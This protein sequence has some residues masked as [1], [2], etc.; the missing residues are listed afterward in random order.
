MRKLGGSP[1]D[2]ARLDSTASFVR[3]IL[4]IPAGLIIDRMKSIKNIYLISSL[5]ILPVQLVKG[6]AQNFQ[7]YFNIRMWEATN[8]R[9][10]MP[11]LNILNISSIK[12]D[13][14]INGMVTRRMA[15]SILG[16]ITPILAAYLITHFGGLENINSYRPLFYTQFVGNLFLFAVM[17]FKIQEPTIN[18]VDKKQNMMLSLKEMFHE[19]PGLKWVLFM[20]VIQFFFFGI[21]AS[22]MGLYFYEV[23]GADAYV[24]ALQST[25]GTLVTLALSVP[26]VRV[27]DKFGRIKMAYFA[28]IV[29]ALC[30]IIPIITPVSN[31]EFLIFYNFFSAIGGAMNLGW[32]A[33]MQEYIPLEYRGRFS[34]LSTTLVALTGIPAPLIGGYLWDMNPD[35]LWW[36]A[37]VWYGII[38]IPLI[39]L[40]SKQ[41]KI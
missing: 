12:N 26:M 8:I 20:Q 9:F 21:R 41:N 28:Q 6:L 39:Y 24:L 13:D 29:F 38:A 1:L 40:V 23:K 17:F 30:V 32:D 37:V 3:M 2:I 19:V 27:I 34:G 22:L 7:T 11:T 14:R 16:I 36:S 18:R 25:V 10:N 35:L 5:L 31:P 4:A 15:M 33:Y